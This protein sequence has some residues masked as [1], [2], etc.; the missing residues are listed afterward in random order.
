M[1][2]DYEKD[3]EEYGDYEKFDKNKVEWKT[4]EGQQDMG[5]DPFLQNYNQ[6]LRRMKTEE[7]E[8]LRKED[9]ENFAEAVNVRNDHLNEMIDKFN[10]ARNSTDFGNSM[11]DNEDELKDMED[12]FDEDDMFHG[13]MS[14]FAKEMLYRNYMKGATVKDLS[15]KYGV[16]PQRVKA[17]IWQKHM[18]WEE[19]YP[20]LGEQHLRASIEMEAM[21]A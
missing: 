13:R 19:V 10:A 15:L 9:E 8:E 3:G 14:P 2:A 16:I 21:Y 5:E 1:G 17:I 4:D 6:M 12:V 20:K 11:K 18:Y 7:G